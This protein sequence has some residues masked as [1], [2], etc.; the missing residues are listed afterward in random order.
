MFHLQKKNGNHNDETDIN[1]QENADSDRDTRTACL[2]KI[3]P[4]SWT[5]QYKN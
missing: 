4:V 2:I 3:V 5:F 1:N